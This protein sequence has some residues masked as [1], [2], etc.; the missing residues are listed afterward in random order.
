M[1]SHSEVLPTYKCF[2]NMVDTQFSTLIR[3]FRA[4]STRE[5]LQDVYYR[6]LTFG[7]RL[8]PLSPISSTFNYRLLNRVAFL[9]S[10]FGHSPDHSTLRLCGCV[11]YIIHPCEWTKLA[12]RYVK[13]LSLGYNDERKGEH[14]SDPI[15]RWMCIFWMWTLMSLTYLFESFFLDLFSEGYL[16]RHFSRHSHNFGRAL[17]H[18]SYWSCCFDCRRFSATISNGFLC[19]HNTWF[20]TFIPMIPPRIFPSFLYLYSSS[21]AAKHTI[22]H[23]SCCNSLHHNHV[24]PSQVVDPQ[25]PDQ[26][27]TLH[28]SYWHV[29]VGWWMI[30]FSS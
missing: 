16:F 10:V 21:L 7:L 5:Y 30:H 27:T 20:Y 25:T 4:D 14:C 28:H 22:K 6:C 19:L 26:P 1:S 9:L 24:M 3:M 15:D 12:T 13:C 17:V 29:E 2:A 8:S 18:F 23:T 11:R